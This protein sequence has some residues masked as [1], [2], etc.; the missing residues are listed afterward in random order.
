MK[1]KY[2]DKEVIAP[3]TVIISAMGQCNDVKKVVTPVLKTTQDNTL[4]YI[5][6]SC[7][8]FN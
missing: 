8:D 1:Q 7:D 5:N 3:G 2:R 6:L 4:Y